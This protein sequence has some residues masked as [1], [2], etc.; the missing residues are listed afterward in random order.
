[1]NDPGP[2]TAYE[3]DFKD[4]FGKHGYAGGISVINGLSGINEDKSTNCDHCGKKLKGRAFLAGDVAKFMHQ[5]CLAD[6]LKTEEG[7]RVLSAW[8]WDTGE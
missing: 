6:Y 8:E 1:M 2:W 5:E 7:V 3:D 4:K